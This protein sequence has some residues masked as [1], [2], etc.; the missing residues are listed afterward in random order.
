MVRF[1]VLLFLT[2]LVVLSIRLNFYFVLCLMFL[3]YFPVLIHW[4]WIVPNCFVKFLVLDLR[5][6][7]VSWIC[8]I[9]LMLIYF[10][11]VVLIFLYRL[12]CI[13]FDI[14]FCSLYSFLFDLVLFFF[15]VYLVYGRQ[16]LDI[17]CHHDMYHIFAIVGNV[18][19]LL[20]FFELVV[21]AMGLSVAMGQVVVPLWY[22]LLRAV[23]M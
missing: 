13:L 22:L 19:C 8:P 16:R 6:L 20:K 23:S 11:L 5:F 21:L 1:L 2:V 18:V 17:S 14:L 15:L 3:M 7:L 10:L 12:Y 9:F 4:F